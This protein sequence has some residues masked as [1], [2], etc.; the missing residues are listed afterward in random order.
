MCSWKIYMIRSK[1]LEKVYIG[2]GID[3]D[4]EIRYHINRAERYKR[5]RCCYVSSYEVLKHGGIV[6]E[7]IEVFVCNNKS[8]LLERVDEYIIENKD[9]SVNIFSAVDGKKIIGK[10]KKRC[11]N[12]IIKRKDELENFIRYN[13]EKK[14]SEG[15]SAEDAKIKARED[16]I[17]VMYEIDNNIEEIYKKWMES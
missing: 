2:S 17:K 1:N 8:E 6:I 11:E 10:T 7:E 14:I 4:K 12:D 9:I 13:V 5:L 15:Y 16:D 3:L